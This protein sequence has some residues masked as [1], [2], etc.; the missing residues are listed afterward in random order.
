MPTTLYN[1]YNNEYVYHLFQFGVGQIVFLLQFITFDW[2]RALKL[3]DLFHRFMY[4]AQTN[5]EVMLLLL[6]V[7]P[8]LVVQLHLHNSVSTVVFILSQKKKTEIV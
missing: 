6:Q 8:L 3:F 1:N 2:Q 7:R 5:V 4:L